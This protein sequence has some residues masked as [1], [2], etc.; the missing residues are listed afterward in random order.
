MKLLSYKLRKQQAER[1]IHKI[2]NPLNDQI[3]IEQEKIQQCFLD[4]YKTLYSQPHIDNNQD[5]NTFL[6]ELELPTVT[7]E[8]NKKLL[9]TITKEEIQLAIKRLKG[10]KMAGADGFGPEWYKIM[11]VFFWSQHC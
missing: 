6:S 1:S 8:Q 4:Y 11:Q 5:I 9:S 10:G 7:E 2:K 3:E